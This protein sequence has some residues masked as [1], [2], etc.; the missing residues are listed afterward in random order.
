MAIERERKFKLKYLPN[1][2]PFEV[3]HQGYLMIDK[4]KQLRVRIIDNTHGFLTYKSDINLT[5]RHEYEYSIPIYDA[6][7]LYNSTN[8]QLQKVRYTLK[9]NDYTAHIDIYGNGLS[10]VEL[11][12]NNTLIQIPDFCGEEITGQKEFSNINIAL[13][14]NK[15]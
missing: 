1:N 3:I 8:Y 4:S 10:V 15:Q 12:F 5:D 7:E 2:L 13:K 9:N 14:N 6:L 11:E